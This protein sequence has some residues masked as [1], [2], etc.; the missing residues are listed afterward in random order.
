MFSHLYAQNNIPLM[1]SPV[2]LR[3]KSCL[4]QIMLL[5][6]YEQ[7]HLGLEAASFPTCKP[8]IV[9]LE[10]VQ[11]ILSINIRTI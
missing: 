8:Q 3:C 1:S 6:M 7:N 10:D 9:R 11:E 5:Q 4:E 2:I